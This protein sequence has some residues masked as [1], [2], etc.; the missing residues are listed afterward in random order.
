MLTEVVRRMFSLLSINASPHT[1]VLFYQP[2]YLSSYIGQN[3]SCQ[4]K[5][6]NH[7]KS[8][9]SFLAKQYKKRPSNQQ[10]KNNV[11][12]FSVNSNI[13]KSDKFLT[14]TFYR[15][16]ILF[17][18]MLA[19]HYLLAHRYSYSQLLLVLTLCSRYSHPPLVLVH[20]YIAFHN[21]PYNWPTLKRIINPIS[22]GPFLQ[23]FTTPLVLTH[24]SSYKCIHNCP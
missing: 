22:Y 13:K 6:G 2:K 3:L 18:V 19:N 11:G 23:L 5:Q 17:K 9:C 7:I 16:T 10:K 24:C 12:K 20:R 8:I 4:K 21:S 14:Y 1:C 15:P